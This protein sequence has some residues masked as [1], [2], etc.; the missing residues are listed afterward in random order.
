MRKKNSTGFKK[1]APT[2]WHAW[3]I[4]LF[5]ADVYLDDDGYFPLPSL[6]PEARSETL[7]EDDDGFQEDNVWG[8][9][10]MIII[11]IIIFLMMKMMIAFKRKREKM[12][13]ILE[14]DNDH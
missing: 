3:L 7:A 11:L 6:A 8:R 5:L 4:F 13:I 2:T 1:L 10:E 14:R 12:I 9:E